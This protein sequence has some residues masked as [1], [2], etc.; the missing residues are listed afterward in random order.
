MNR[1]IITEMMSC[2]ARRKVQQLRRAAT[3]IL[4]NFCTNHARTLETEE[5]ASASILAHRT[6]V[7][8][9]RL[10]RTTFCAPLRV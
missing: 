3:G 8:S 4:Q 2:D 10:V 9:V 1:D 5:V 6:I 7:A